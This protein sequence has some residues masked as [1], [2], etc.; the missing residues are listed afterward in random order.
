MVDHFMEVGEVM[1]MV[2]LTG[3]DGDIVLL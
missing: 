1:V 2:V 3:E